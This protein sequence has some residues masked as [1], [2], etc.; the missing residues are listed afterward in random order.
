VLA[1]LLS[2]WEPEVALVPDHPPE[3]LHAVAFAVDQV[4][5]LDA[6]ALTVVGLALRDTVGAG[7]ALTVTVTD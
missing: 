2:D 1:R 7:G 5:V 3:A 6:P 4:S